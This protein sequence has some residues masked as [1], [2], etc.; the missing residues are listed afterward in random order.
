MLLPAVHSHFF[1]QKDRIQG[2]DTVD[3]CQ[4]V[5][6]CNLIA[7]GA[8]PLVRSHKRHVIMM[9][10]RILL[11]HKMNFHFHLIF[12]YINLYRPHTPLPH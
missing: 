4:M 12:S 6:L 3:V 10:I 9:I 5:A 1:S 8:L 11:T 7:M 2:V